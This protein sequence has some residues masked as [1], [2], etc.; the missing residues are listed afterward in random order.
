MGTFVY[1]E[2]PAYCHVYSKNC[3][4]IVTENYFEDETVLIILFLVQLGVELLKLQL[5]IPK[6]NLESI[7]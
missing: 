2:S 3:P 5:L 6:I 1:F 7:C 4:A